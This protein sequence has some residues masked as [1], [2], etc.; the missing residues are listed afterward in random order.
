MVG[1]PGEEALWLLVLSLP[2]RLVLS[3][4]GALGQVLDTDTT[5]NTQH[6]DTTTTRSNIQHCLE[7][8]V[9]S[10]TNILIHNRHIETKPVND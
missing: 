6:T 4:A 3:L 5:S 9:G 7:C 10:S 1:E 2:S 8:L